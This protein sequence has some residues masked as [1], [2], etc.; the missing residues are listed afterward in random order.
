MQDVTPVRIDLAGYPVMEKLFLN[1]KM[2]CIGKVS[3]SIRKISILLS[4]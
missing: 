1:L 4:I 3:I 2:E